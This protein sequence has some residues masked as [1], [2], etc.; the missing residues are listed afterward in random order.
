[1]G[2]YLPFAGRNAIAEMS[3]GIQ[4][5]F[6]FDQQQIRESL[7]AIKVDFAKEFPRFEPVQMFSLNLG[8]QPYPVAGGNPAATLSGF[9]LVKAKTDGTPGRVLRAMANVLS[10]HFLEYTSWK[11]TKPQAINYFTRCLEKMAIMGHNSATS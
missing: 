10:V 4:F 11:E 1:M 6:P 9:N 7:E 2:K 8:M 3:V 5:G